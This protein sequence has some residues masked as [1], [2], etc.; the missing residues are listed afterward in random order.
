[1]VVTLGVLLVVYLF[2]RFTRLGLAMRAVAYNAESS[3]LVGIRV[4]WMLALGWGFAAAIG[5]VGRALARHTGPVK[6]RAPPRDARLVETR[7]T[8]TST[9][10]LAPVAMA[11]LPPSTRSYTVA[12]QAMQR[13][14]AKQPGLRGRVQVSEVLA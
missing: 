11:E 9:A 12:A 14:L 2:F 6:Y 4:G 3:R 13:H 1:M 8:V 7:Y 5:A 10:D